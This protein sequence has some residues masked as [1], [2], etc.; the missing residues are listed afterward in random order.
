VESVRGIEVNQP[1]NQLTVQANQQQEGGVQLSVKTPQQKTRLFGLHSVPVTFV[2][3]VNAQTQQLKEPQIKTIHH[4][5]LEQ[6]QQ[7]VNKVVGKQAFELPLQVQGHYH[8]PASRASYK[9]RVQLLMA[10][11][12]T[13][14]VSFVPNEQT[15]KQIVFR[16]SGSAFQK[17]AQQEHKPKMDSFY[18]NAVKFERG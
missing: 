15:P 14:H 13:V 12:N 11:D 5:R 6:L 8:A 4:E 1:I 7:D 18:S 16:L 2:R 3:Q 17:V 9:Q 10:T